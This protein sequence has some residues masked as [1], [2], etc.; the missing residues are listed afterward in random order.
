MEITPQL[1]FEGICLL[2]MPL[3]KNFEYYIEQLLQSNM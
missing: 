3:G 2:K 1:R